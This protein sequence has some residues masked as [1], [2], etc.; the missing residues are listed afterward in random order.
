MTSS[1]YTLPESGEG[2]TH[3]PQ[4]FLPPHPQ[5]PLQLHGLINLWVNV[6]ST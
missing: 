3:P 1:S 5:L 6:G 2:V 4:S